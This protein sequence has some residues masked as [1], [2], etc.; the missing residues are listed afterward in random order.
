[1]YH[2]AG[3]LVM[4]SFY[5][6]FGLPALEAMHCDCPVIVSNRASLPEVVVNAGLLLDP[7]DESAWIVAMG[8]ILADSGLRAK[9]VEDGRIQARKFTWRRTAEKTL[10]LYLNQIGLHV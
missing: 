10:A 1:M 5:E 7:D 8:Q 9:M 3:V 2:A 6:G 4:P